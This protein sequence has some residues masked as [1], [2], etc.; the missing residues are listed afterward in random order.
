[1]LFFKAS[2]RR[3]PARW[4]DTKKQ[5][6]L[7]SQTAFTRKIDFRNFTFDIQSITLS[8]YDQGSKW[9]SCQKRKESQTSAVTV[10]CKGI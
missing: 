5:N 1:M 4:H 2:V 8:H 7:G 3:T 6:H 10:F 9:Q